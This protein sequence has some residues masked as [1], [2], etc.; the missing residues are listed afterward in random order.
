[1]N[2]WLVTDNV[3][4][5]DCNNL[6]ATY[7]YEATNEEFTEDILDNP[8]YSSTDKLKAWSTGRDRVFGFIVLEDNYNYMGAITFPKKGMYISLDGV[9]NATISAEG[10]EFKE[11]SIKPLDT[12]YLPKS[13]QFGETTTTS[14][15]LTWDGDTEGRYNVSG[16][17]YKV[18]DAMPTLA[19]L[20]NGGTISYMNTDEPFTSS[21]VVD[22]E[23]AGIG[24]G[25]IIIT[26]N[27]GNPLAGVALKVGATATMNG[28]TLT[29]EETGVFFLRQQI[30]TNAYVHIEKLTINGY[31]GF[32]ITEIET[33][34]PKFTLI[35]KTYFYGGGNNLYIDEEHT[36]PVTNVDVKRAYDKGLIEVIHTSSHYLVYSVNF[37]A[38]P[39]QV[40]LSTQFGSYRIGSA[41]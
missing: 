20:L 28:V 24:E 32:E 25:G 11:G 31:A 2:A 4:L 21:N 35:P 5:F 36:I 37:T 7:I 9:L 38:Y 3:D 34:D 12:K 1:M 8:V 14:D 29:F 15:T 19:D 33:I 23:A 16:M 30:S 27:S 22:V 41:D 39:L 26:N 18:S 10:Y 40:E 6:T 13:H 17:F